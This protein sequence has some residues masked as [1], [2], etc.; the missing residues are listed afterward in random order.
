MSTELPWILSVADLDELTAEDV[1]RDVPLQVAD[2]RWYL[3]G[4]SGEAAYEAGHL[5]GAT[6]V[7][8]E[9]VLASP[10]TA[11]E[12]RHPL[13][14]PE[15]FAAGMEIA[16]ITDE[17]LVVAYDDAGGATASRLVWLLRASGHQAAVLEGGLRAWT[18]VHGEDALETGPDL[19]LPAADGS[20][21]ASGWD[22]HWFATMDE[23]QAQ[24]AG[25]GVV[26]DSRAPERYR[27]ETE[28]VD[29]RAGHVPGA[30]N[31]FH[32][33]NLAEDQTFLDE[34]ALRARLAEAG[35]DAVS[36]DDPAPIVYCGSGVTATHNLVLLEALGLHGRLYP[37]SWSQYA[38]TDRPLER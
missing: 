10:A 1:E 4:R 36:E 27:G 23:T 13:P 8:L 3:D 35:L 34:D 22:D 33:G 31:L 38:A 2:V 16:G 25:D 5:P 9:T 17:T 18:A 12:G 15:T 11:E 21:T 20:F 28:P 24:A 7:D 26:V 29:A 19:V 32:A 37:G 6:F 30:V 14:L